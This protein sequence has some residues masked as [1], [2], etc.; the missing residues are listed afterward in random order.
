MNDYKMWLSE[1]FKTHTPQVPLAPEDNYFA[2]GAIDSF[3]VIELIEAVEQQFSVRFTQDDFQDPRFVSVNGLAALL[4]EK[5][6][7]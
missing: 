2:A 1:W 5:V 4:E 3:G 6:S 7:Q